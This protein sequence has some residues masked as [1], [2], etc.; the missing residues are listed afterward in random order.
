MDKYGR[1]IVTEKD[2]ETDEWL[3][4]MVQFFGTGH[5]K[6]KMEIGKGRNLEEAYS[7]TI[8]SLLEALGNIDIVNRN[9]AK[10]IKRYTNNFVIPKQE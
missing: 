1:N 5:E 6:Q 3:V 2:S 7:K 4:F 10:E 9:A 8:K